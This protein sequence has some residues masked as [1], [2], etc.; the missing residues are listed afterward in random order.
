MKAEVGMKT[1]WA[2][3]A[4]VGGWLALTAAINVDQRRRLRRL[5]ETRAGVDA[6]ASVRESLPE[7]P[8]DLLIEVYSAVQALVP[9]SEFPVKADDDLLHT[10][11]IDQGYLDD[12]LEEFFVGNRQPQAPISTFADLAKAVWTS[13]RRVTF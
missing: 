7:I 6:F 11:E 13:R 8:E 5:A 9:G 4:L 2:V 3:L 12:L 10:L 1:L